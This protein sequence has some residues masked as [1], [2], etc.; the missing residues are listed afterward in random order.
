MGSYLFVAGARPAR[1]RE[2]GPPDDRPD[3]P[4]GWV[5]LPPGEAGLRATRAVVTPG[6][7]GVCAAAACSAPELAALAAALAEAEEAVGLPVGTIAVMPALE[8]AAG[9]LG[10]AELARAPRVSRLLLGEAALRAELRMAPGPDEGELLWLRSTVVVASAAARIGAPVADEC[11]DQ[12]RF[13]ESCAA[14]ARL[15]F[16]GRLCADDGQLR[17]AGEIF[18]ST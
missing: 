15:G 18:A 2:A 4:G 8:T 13:A 6:L 16:G 1:L 14:L 3:G 17:L 5:R 10:A 7:A 11:P 12:G 9:V